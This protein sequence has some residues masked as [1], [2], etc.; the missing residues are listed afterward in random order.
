MKDKK[1]DWRKATDYP[2]DYSFDRWAYEFELRGA[3]RLRPAIPSNSLS[4]AGRRNLKSDAPVVYLYGPWGIA[5]TVPNAEGFQ[6][7][8][9][10]QEYDHRKHQVLL[11]MMDDNIDEQIESAR[12]RLKQLQ[13]HLFST[14]AARKRSDKYQ[15]YLR[16]LDAERENATTKEMAVAIFPYLS[17]EQPDYLA[18][19]RVENGLKAAHRLLKCGVK[20]LFATTNR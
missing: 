17:N 5:P 11:F 13:E 3:P 14:P 20:P 18:T 4:E 1:P 2:K 9:L 8:I 7:G 16:L 10:P 6:F 12:T 19:K 15:S